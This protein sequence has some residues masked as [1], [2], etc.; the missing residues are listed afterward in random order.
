MVVE[1][2]SWAELGALVCLSGELQGLQEDQPGKGEHGQ[3]SGEET[4]VGLPA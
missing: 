2:L 4:R 1:E 3:R